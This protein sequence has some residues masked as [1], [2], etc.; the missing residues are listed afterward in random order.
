MFNVSSTCTFAAASSA[1]TCEGWIVA[2]FSGLG[3]DADVEGPT[4]H[5]HCV[6]WVDVSENS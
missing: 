3:R 2:G 5:A 1:S 6:I 4:Y